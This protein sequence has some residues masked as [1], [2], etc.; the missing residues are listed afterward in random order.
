ML[1]STLRARV[2]RELKWLRAWGRTEKRN[3]LWDV[4]AALI[5]DLRMQGCDARNAHLVFSR[6]SAG[7]T[8]GAPVVLSRRFTPIAV[9]KVWDY[10]FFQKIWGNIESSTLEQQERAFW[11]IIDD[12]MRQVY[13][14]AASA[15]DEST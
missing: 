4:V 10:P 9:I 12:V 3:E 8:I 11:P 2:F 7:F 15:K 14:K 1:L 6:H 5:E 13:G